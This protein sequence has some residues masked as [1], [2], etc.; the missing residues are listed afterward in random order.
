MF[1]SAPETTSLR[2]PPSVEV[3]VLSI[4]MDEN[5]SL[6]A[7][8]RGNIFFGSIY[9]IAEHRNRLKSFKLKL[10]THIYER[11]TAI[12]RRESYWFELYTENG[13]GSQ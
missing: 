3:S 6:D 7:E 13:N 4:H 1:A 5:E 12:S 2:S 9:W 8:T 10:N 11:R